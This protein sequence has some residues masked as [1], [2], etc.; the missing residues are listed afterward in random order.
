M[1]RYACSVSNC[2]RHFST[3]S[4]TS[5]VKGHL[6]DHGFLNDGQARLMKICSLD[7]EPVKLPEQRQKDFFKSLCAWIID[8]RMKFSTV[9]NSFFKDMIGCADRTLAVPCGKTMTPKVKG[10]QEHNEIKMRYILSSISGKVR[11]TTDPWSLR[12]Y[13]GFLSITFH[14]VVK[15]W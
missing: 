9:D 5:T 6:K 4:S 14:W 3:R 7:R 1:V 10:M 12:D 11:L 2:R 15:H 8:S 13:R